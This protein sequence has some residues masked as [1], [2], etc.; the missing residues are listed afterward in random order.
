MH[1][2]T[3]IMP[4]LFKTFEEANRFAKRDADS[5]AKRYGYQSVNNAWDIPTMLQT[6]HNSKT[7]K[8]TVYMHQWNLQKFNLEEGE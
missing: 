5:S 2:E 6:V 1:G 4:N 8:D 7:G 3:I